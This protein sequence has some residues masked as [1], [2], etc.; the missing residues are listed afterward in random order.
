MAKVIS[1]VTKGTKKGDKRTS[2]YKIFLAILL[3]DILLPAAAM[4]KK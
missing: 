3:E 4:K 2:M 1:R